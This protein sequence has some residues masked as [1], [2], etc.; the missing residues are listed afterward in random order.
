MAP[1]NSLSQDNGAG[2]ASTD[3]LS[4]SVHDGDPA[5]EADETGYRIKEQE[6]G[7]KRQI[8]VILMGAGASTLNFLKKAEEELEKVD[9]VCYE[10]NS[11]VGGT[12]LENRYPGNVYPRPYFTW[13]NE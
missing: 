2:V 11:D 10:K 3:T 12:W 6:Y 9:I 8:R 1:P 13:S 5:P 7:T 4:W